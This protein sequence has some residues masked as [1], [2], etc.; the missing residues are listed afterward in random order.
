MNAG[1]ARERGL[2]MQEGEPWPPPAKPPKRSRFGGIGPLLVVAAIVLLI[3]IAAAS[4][5]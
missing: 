1:V 5:R 2:T 3:A 4:L